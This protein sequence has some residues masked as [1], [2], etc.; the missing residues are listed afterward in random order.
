MRYGKHTETKLGIGLIER[1]ITVLVLFAC[2]PA[3]ARISL[4]RLPHAAHMDDSVGGTAMPHSPADE[5]HSSSSSSSNHSVARAFELARANDFAELASLLEHEP[6]VA[7]AIEPDSKYSLLHI[8]SRSGNYHAVEELIVQWHCDVHHRDNMFRV[9]LHY[10][11]Q[12]DTFSPSDEAVLQTIGILVGAGSRVTARDNTGM[13]IIHYAVQ[14]GREAIV[15]MLLS[16]RVFVHTIAVPR[17][18]PKTPDDAA[19]ATTHGLPERGAR[20]LRFFHTSLLEQ[21]KRDTPDAETRYALVQ[22]SLSLPR[23]PIECENNFE[24]RPL[25]LAA[26]AGS[27]SVVRVL[28]NAGANATATDYRGR[29]PL[30]HA[31]LRGE[32]RQSLATIAL[33]SPLSF[34]VNDADI[35][36]NTALMLAAENGFTAVVAQLL[37]NRCVQ[38]NLR[39]KQGLTA[40]QLAQKQGFQDIV[41]LL[42]ASSLDSSTKIS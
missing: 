10:A 7:R 21:W 39:N 17:S 15:S 30:M 37:R 41:E 26:R 18:R 9:P 28:L 8:F 23:A 2:S 12:A 19:A 38:P 24:E 32:S 20:T 33:L 1:A 4:I 25:H 14:G 22:Q 29:T 36:G 40:L 34:H 31:V 27:L 35:D 16:M 3:A 42:L 13:G 5:S 6:T 11:V